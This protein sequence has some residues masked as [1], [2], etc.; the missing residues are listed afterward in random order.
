MFSDAIQAGADNADYHTHREEFL[1]FLWVCGVI[2]MKITALKMIR[3]TFDT[4]L[5]PA[6]NTFERLFEQKVFETPLPDTDALE[7]SM[8]RAVV[9]AQHEEIERQ[10]KLRLSRI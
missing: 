8:L 5:V 4:G 7:L 2:G 3:R 1:K 9:W 10:N 6:K